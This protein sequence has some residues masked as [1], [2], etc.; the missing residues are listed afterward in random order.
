MFDASRPI[1]SSDSCAHLERPAEEAAHDA[2]QAAPRHSSPSLGKNGRDLARAY[3]LKFVVSQAQAAEIESL[4][5]TKLSLDPHVDPEMDRG[6]RVATLY[7]DTPQRHVFHRQGRFKLFKLRLR[8]YGLDQS[9]YLE[10]KARRKD[11]VRKLRSS[12]EIGVL[13]NFAAE[14]FPTNGFGGWYH[15]Q[16]R[17]NGLQPA[18]L[19]EYHRTAYFGHGDEGAIRLTFDRQIRGGLATGWSFELP[20]RF[21]SILTDQVICEFKFR[22]N[23]P[24]VFKSVIEAKQLVPGRVS[25]Y[26]LCML[27][28]DEAA[29]GSSAH[30]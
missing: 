23:L 14:V 3:E 29:A 7:C 25:K 28:L 9:V 30:G 24:S 6:Y 17:R 16:L 8:K 18:C 19:I 15:R 13:P 27:A 11:F 10:R 26:R 4:L 1:S 20:Q 22:G 12:V 5:A 2:L 21:A